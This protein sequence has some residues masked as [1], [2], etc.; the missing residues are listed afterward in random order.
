MRI[1][2]KR[3]VALGQIYLVRHGETAWNKARIFRGRRDIPLDE[4][5]R[6]EAACAAQALRDVPLRRIYTSPLS[7][8]RDTAEAIA[9][10]RRI[11]VVQD[12]V[13]TDMDYGEWTEYWDVEAR[14]KFGEQY[15]LWQ[16]APHRVK[17]PG[18]ESLDDVRRRAAS[19]LLALAREHLRDTIALV[20]HRVVLKLLLLEAKGLDNSHFWA[21]RLDTGAISVLECEAGPGS[22]SG[23]LRVVVENDTRH[24]RALAEHSSRDF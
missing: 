15:R 21:V 11:E 5:G 20:T 22:G 6:R 23:T 17:F 3:E 19:R 14:E 13:F 8:A 4:Q 12:A 9:A 24:L 16:E 7:R 10:D 18:G 1:S 2:D